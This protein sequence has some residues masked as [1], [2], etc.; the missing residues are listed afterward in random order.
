[1]GSLS[2]L[3]MTQ[4]VKAKLLISFPIKVGETALYYAAWKGHSKIAI[5]LVEANADIDQQ[6]KVKSCYF[7]LHLHIRSNE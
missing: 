4:W 1:M 6:N 7:K 3:L 5:L 2:G